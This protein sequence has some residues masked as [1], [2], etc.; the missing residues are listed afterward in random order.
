MIYYLNIISAKVN[1]IYELKEDLVLH[2]NAN[3][4]TLQALNASAR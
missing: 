3:S 4:A 2:H 1:I